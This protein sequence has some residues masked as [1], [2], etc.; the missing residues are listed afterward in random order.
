MSSPFVGEIRIFAG[1]FAPLNW[2]LCNGQIMSIAENEVLYQLIGTTYGGDGVNTFALPNLQSRVP[3]HQ[4]TL[5]GGG[6]YVIGQLGGVETVALTTQ[7]LPV[8]NHTLG[9]STSGQVLA[10]T[11]ST[12]LGA[13]TAPAQPGTTNTYGPTPATSNLNPN[14]LKPDGGGQPHNN[15][16]PCV[17]IYYIIALYGI[18]PTQS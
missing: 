10:P 5:T 2:A 4:G 15:I 18:F 7:Q 3:I 16:Q 9:A 6:T 13:A 14:T 17:A 8:H 11:A 12:I 1:N